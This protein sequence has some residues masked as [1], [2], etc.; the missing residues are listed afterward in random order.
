MFYTSLQF[1]DTN[2]TQLSKIKHLLVDLKEL[3]NQSPKECPRCGNITIQSA[4][5]GKDSNE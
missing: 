4:E 3:K 5:L 2:I 1:N